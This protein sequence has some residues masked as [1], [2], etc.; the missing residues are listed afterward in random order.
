MPHSLPYLPVTG[1]VQAHLCI[2]PSGQRF[3]APP[4][5]GRDFN[6]HGRGRPHIHRKPRCRGR[7]L[8][9]S[10]ATLPVFGGAL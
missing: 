3:G 6:F 4:F 8:H 10:G 2:A 7:Q 9:W 5:G 1:L